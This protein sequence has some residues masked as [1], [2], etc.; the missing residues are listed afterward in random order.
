MAIV[1]AELIGRVAGQDE[2]KDARN[3]GLGDKQKYHGPRVN[4]SR[5][6]RRVGI[7]F[8]EEH[9]PD[10]TV[11]HHLRTCSFHADHGGSCTSI[12][13][14]EDGR[15]AFKCQHDRCL[16]YTIDNLFR[17][18]GKPL[19]D[20]YEQEP[21]SPPAHWQMLDAAKLREWICAPLIWIVEGIVA[22]GNLVFVAAE[23]QCGKTLIGLYIALMMLRG[24]KLFGEFPIN[25]V[26]KV[27]YLVLEDPARRIKDRLLDMQREGD[28]A[29]EEG[30]L[31][32]HVAPGLAISDDLHFKYLEDLIQREGF[33]VVFL[34][35]YQRATPGVDS[36]NDERQ[37]LILHKIADLT[38]KLGVTLWVH[39]HFRKTLGGQK[40]RVPNL[41]DIKGT[42]GKAQNADAFLL[43]DRTGSRLRIQGSS[44][45]S[46]K[47][48]GFYV[49]IAPQ[50]VTDQPKFTYAG[51]IEELAETSRDKKAKNI[52]SV[53][54]ALEEAGD[55]AK[56]EAIAG[57]VGLSPSTVAR[58]LDTLI[59]DGLA[60][61]MGR[62][63][64]T[65][66]RFKGSGFSAGF[67][68]TEET[69][70]KE[71]QFEWNQ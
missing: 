48:I 71:P 42:G 47:P 11:K 13:Q 61:R 6:L 41:N 55:W 39:D 22:R 50:G 68:S 66:Y 3:N 40:R 17:K 28:P 44:K 26:N 10:G 67:S 45:D 16:N 1:T 62:G 33:D 24:G 35:T 59:N 31:V 64:N 54:K 38:R 43:M 34:D 53:R 19:E 2:P 60:E 70:C 21:F 25:P 5:W 23:S 36:S 56:C 20:E 4:V 49:D 14:S 46:D 65:M 30:C 9:D 58:H 69:P 12:L 32:F 63:K 29:I 57:K 15:L 51:T 37:S 7:E 18:I 8:S 27:L 52:E